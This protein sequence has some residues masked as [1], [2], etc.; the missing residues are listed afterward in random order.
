MPRRRFRAG[1][2]IVVLLAAAGLLARNVS[3]SY[4]LGDDAFI[5]FRYAD[6]LVRGDGLV[7]NVGERVEGYT[8]FLWV[9]LMAASLAVG[10]PPE[11]SSNVLGIAS[12]AAF[13]IALGWFAA[14]RNGLDAGVALLLVLLAGSR[15]FGAWC[16]G[17]L[18]TMFFTLL[19]FLA[20]GRFVVERETSSE[21]PWLSALLFGLAS[22]TR[23]EGLL[24]SAVAGAAFLLDLMRGRRTPGAVVRWAMPLA[25]L[26][27]AHF[28]FRLAYYGEWLPNTFY[29]KV[30]GLWL[31][32]GLGY[33]ALFHRSYHVAWFLPLLV[34][35]AWG[36]GAWIAR[37]FLS[38]LC[39][40]LLYVVCVG[41]DRFEFRFL[42]VVFPYLYWLLVEGI[43]RLWQLVPSAS[44]RRLA[45]RSAS[46]VLSVALLGTTG[47]GGGRNVGPG[48]RFGN[49]DV[50]TVKRYADDRARQGR[51]LR[52]FIEQ[53]RLPAELMAATGGV[54]AIPYYTR[55]TTV[56]RHGLNDAY[57][58]RLPLPRRGLIAHEHDAPWDYLVARRVVVFDVFNRMIGKRLEPLGSEEG[59][60]HDGRPLKLR[61]VRID[62]LYMNFATF[63][64]D[65]ELARIFAGCEI[66]GVADARPPAPAPL[67]TPEAPSPGAP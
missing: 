28:A 11:L 31:D 27:G 25:L 57:I 23:P 3:R 14:R 9:L 58:A 42:V 10:V 26:V 4:F 47:F 55:W 53:G 21:R 36:P 66:L 6:N 65:D 49:V 35:A 61:A 19:V 45:V 56:D 38:V 63:V 59:P 40:Y 2:A 33:L 51:V 60:R 39:S 18:E 15:S 50:E 62:G 37:L 29:A 12:G 67:P 52:T 54:G 32:N 34:L 24:F 13:L 48:S 22:L 5:S 20:F 44:G 30:A 41:G 64:P 8:N 17:G 46:V 43:R 1:L 16:T 7:W